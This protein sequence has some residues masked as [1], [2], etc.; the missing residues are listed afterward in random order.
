MLSHD[1]LFVC[2]FRTCFFFTQML[3]ALDGILVK[4]E[5][6]A[7]KKNI[8][9]DALLHARLFPDMF[10]L[11]RQVQIACDFSRGVCARMAGI[12]VPKTDDTE[13]TFAE[14]AYAYR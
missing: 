13:K 10:A 3:G 6:H 4:A 11:T 9:P 8:E 12:D 2:G 1:H 14:P 7:S 5:S